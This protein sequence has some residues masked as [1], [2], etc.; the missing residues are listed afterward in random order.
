MRP[1]PK[2]ILVG[3]PSRLF[4]IIQGITLLELT[5]VI[6]VLLSLVSSLFLGAQAWNRG[7]DR[8]M[9][10]MNLHIVQKGVCSYSNLHG[11]LPGQSVTGLQSR[12]FGLGNFIEEIPE[13]PA[14]G[15]YTMGPTY[16]AD[17]IPPV[18]EIYME[19]SLVAA[20]HLPDDHGAW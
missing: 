20:G 3:R 1:H 2:N 8:T 9:C 17:T 6:L 12:I 16:G 5:V 14:S 4:G 15:T 11:H 7:S 10:I 13:C 18:E 19:C